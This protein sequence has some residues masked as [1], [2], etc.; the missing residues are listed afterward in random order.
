M[1]YTPLN[2]KTILE[3]KKYKIGIVRRFQYA[4]CSKAN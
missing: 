4:R 3:P 2:Y 1:V